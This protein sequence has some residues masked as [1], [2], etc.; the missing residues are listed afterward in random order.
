MKFLVTL[1]LKG[2]MKSVEKR[3]SWGIISREKFL[4]LIE[5]AHQQRVINDETAFDLTTRA[6]AIPAE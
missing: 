4:A 3:K 2:C 1:V 5:E 6:T